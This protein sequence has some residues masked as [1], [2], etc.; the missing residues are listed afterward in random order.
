M[1]DIK[2]IINNS[3]KL[4]LERRRDGLSQAEVADKLGV[5]QTTYA[6]REKFPFRTSDTENEYMKVK[7]N[8][9]CV[10][11]RRRESMKQIDIAKRLGVCRYTVN[12]M[13]KGQVDCARL[14]QLW[15]DYS[16]VALIEAK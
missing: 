6:K 9:A 11:L 15:Q 5:S 2:M 10:V 1:N 12:K 14:A 3:E 8:E 4:F 7:V 16:G 13:E